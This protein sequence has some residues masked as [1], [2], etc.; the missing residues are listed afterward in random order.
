MAEQQHVALG[1][2]VADLLLP[3]VVVPLVGQQ[4]HHEIAAA[5]GLDDGQHLEALLARLGDRGGVLAQ[6][7]D[8]VD[9]GV[10]QVEGVGVAL[11]AVADDRDGLAVEQVRSASSS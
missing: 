8:D 1:D 5:G 4:D 11:G 2:A 10:L 6:A 7:D 9:A 3:D